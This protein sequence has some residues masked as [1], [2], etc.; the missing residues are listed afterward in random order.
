MSVD[1]GDGCFVVCIHCM[2]HSDCGVGWCFFSGASFSAQELELLSH[3]QQLHEELAV[4]RREQEA[5]RKAQLERQRHRSSDS[6]GNSTGLPQGPTVSQQQQQPQ[7]GHQEGQMSGMG[8]LQSLA[9]STTAA[10]YGNGG[11]EV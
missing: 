5:E 9:K 6:V 1:E 11:P 8:G 10:P 4:K 2:C 7:Q 3:L